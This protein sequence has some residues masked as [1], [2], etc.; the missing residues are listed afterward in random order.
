MVETWMSIEVLYTVLRSITTVIQ[1]RR[2]LLFQDTNRFIN[3]WLRSR[4][5]EERDT[6]LTMLTPPQRAAHLSVEIRKTQLHLSTV[7]I[8]LS[9]ST[10]RIQLSSSMVQS[11]LN[12]F[13]ILKFSGPSL[14]GMTSSTFQPHFLFGIFIMKIVIVILCTQA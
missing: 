5:H 1:Y 4:R 8:H 6:I 14:L 12:H 10:V 13:K 7:K 11:Q 9:S 2:T 3:F